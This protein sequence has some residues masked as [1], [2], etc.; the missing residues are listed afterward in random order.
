MRK[1]E[2]YVIIGFI[3][4]FIFLL[5]LIW[6]NRKGTIHTNNETIIQPEF[7]TPIMPTVNISI[8]K[9]GDNKSSK[10]NTC[11]TDVAIHQQEVT[12]ILKDKQNELIANLDA[13]LNEV[14]VGG[15]YVV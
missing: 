10:C 1:N 9:N 11:S 7:L 6:K 5:W 3:L 13:I 15:Y 4:L 2:T 12:N 8:A 14:K